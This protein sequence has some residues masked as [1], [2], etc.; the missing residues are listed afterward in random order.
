MWQVVD[1]AELLFSEVLNALSQIAEEKNIAGHHVGANGSHD[2]RRQ[3]GRLEDMLQ[4]EKMEF[5]VYKPFS[6]LYLLFLEV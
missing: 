1:R 3:I 4:R 2:L 6:L 5:D